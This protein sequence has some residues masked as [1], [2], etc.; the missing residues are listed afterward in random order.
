MYWG[1]EIFMQSLSSFSFCFFKPSY[2][3]Y[4]FDLS[5]YSSD[6]T[7]KHTLRV[8]LICLEAREGSVGSYSAWGEM[9][10]LWPLPGVTRGRMKRCNIYLGHRSPRFIFRE[11]AWWINATLTLTISRQDILDFINC[12][13]RGRLLI[14]R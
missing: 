1:E 11:I 2:F 8:L 3:D 9:N 12:G 14:F 7:K 6:S 13:D 4:S 10:Y 5:S